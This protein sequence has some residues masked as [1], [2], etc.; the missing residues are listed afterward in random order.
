MI[1][2]FDKFYFGKGYDLLTDNGYIQWDKTKTKN[3]DLYHGKQDSSLI[4]YSSLFED[5]EINLLEDKHCK[6]VE[7]LKIRNPKWQFLLKKDEYAS[8]KEK[9]D[10]TI[11]YISETLEKHRYTSY[12]VEGN[13]I[14]NN[15]KPIKVDRSLTNVFLEKEKNPTV[16][17]IISS[18]I[19]KDKSDFCEPIKYD[20]L[21][22]TTGRL[23]VKSGPNILLLPKNAKKI[24]VSKYGKKGKILFVDFVSLEPRFTKLLFSENT[25]IDIY[26]D[27][28][29]KYNLHIN[30]EKIKL[31]VLSTLFGA[32]MQKIS[33][34]LGEEAFLVRK[35]IIDYFKIKEISKKIGSLKSGKIRNFFDRPIKLKNKAENVALNNYIQSSCVDVSLIGFS[36]LLKNESLPNS[37]VPLGII[38]D[39]LV[40]DIKNDELEI[41]QEILN[42]GVYIEGLG[43]F[44]IGCE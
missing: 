37:V 30:R 2:G 28:S 33:K 40:I 8:F 27:I 35:A 10:E 17:S 7:Q 23:I 21:K 38:H 22:T 3:F 4:K 13:H 5:R 42:D 9:I 43:K 44:Y 39:A 16:K 26:S 15:I 36:K 32:G 24:I 19:P 25:E 12:F 6:V 1:V 11:R 14:I 20:R 34:I 41:F 29:K 31:A 18:F